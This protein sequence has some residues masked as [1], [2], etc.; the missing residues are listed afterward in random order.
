MPIKFPKSGQKMS[1][2]QNDSS[3]TNLQKIEFIRNLEHAAYFE[4][5]VA[6]LLNGSRDNEKMR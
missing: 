2:F 4:F 5:F 1:E 3:Y 6:E